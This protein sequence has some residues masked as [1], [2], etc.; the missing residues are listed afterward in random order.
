MSLAWSRIGFRDRFVQGGQQ[1]WVALLTLID[2]GLALFLRHKRHPRLQGEVAEFV[3]TQVVQFSFNFCQA[4]SADNIV[5]PARK[6]KMLS[7]DRGMALDF[8]AR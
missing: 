6:A 4:H 7:P 5:L 8:Q 1:T 3:W 2:P